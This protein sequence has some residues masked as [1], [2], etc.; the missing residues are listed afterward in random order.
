MNPI[1]W[2]PAIDPYP[3]LAD[4][5]LW[6][7]LLPA[8]YILDGGYQPRGLLGLLNGLRCEGATL[9]REGAIVRLGPGTMADAEYARYKRDWLSPNAAKV[10]ALLT[11][12]GERLER[13]EANGAEPTEEGAA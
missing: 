4:H 13:L 8:A 2:N 7:R 10:N 11:E 3:D 5:Y 9:S 1:T 6:A 12:L